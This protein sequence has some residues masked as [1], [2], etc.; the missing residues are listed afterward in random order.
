MGKSG[1]YR[2]AIED[3]V[4]GNITYSW[5]KYPCIVDPDND[6]VYSIRIEGGAIKVYEELEVPVELAT[7]TGF[8]T[9]SYTGDGSESQKIEG[10]GFQPKYV[11]IWVKDPTDGNPIAIFET[12]AEILDDHASGM[13]V[14]HEGADKEHTVQNNTIVSLDSGGFT[15]DDNKVDEHPNK[16]DQVYNYL[17]QR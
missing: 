15:V 1:R 12:T 9:G 13:S 14:M 8:K 11:K 5:S 3:M 10:I 6:K 16:S 17:A 7:A 2:I 4:T